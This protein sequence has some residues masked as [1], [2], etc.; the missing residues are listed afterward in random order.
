MSAVVND[1]KKSQKVIELLSKGFTLISKSSYD[2]YF[3][4]SGLIDFNYSNSQGF[5]ELYKQFRDCEKEYKH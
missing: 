4:H 1:G 3:Q 5:N 2:E